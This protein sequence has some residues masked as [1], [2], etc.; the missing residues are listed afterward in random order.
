MYKK[1]VP[2]RRKRRLNPA[3][4]VLA[5]PCR[6]RNMEV[7]MNNQ[8][9]NENESKPAKCPSCEAHG[10]TCQRIYFAGQEVFL[11]KCKECGT[12]VG[13]FNGNK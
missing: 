8:K 11:I 13:A 5:E 4:H 1:K 6:Y 2:K 9:E 3:R 7:D 12:V 10:F